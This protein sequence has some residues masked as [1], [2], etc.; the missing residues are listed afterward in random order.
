VKSLPLVI[1]LLCASAAFAEP[2]EGSVAQP[3]NSVAELVNKQLLAPIQKAE[4]RRSRF[5]RAAP[6]TRERRLRVLDAVAQTDRRGKEFYRFVI[7]E[8]RPFDEPDEWH[9]DSLIGCA[10]PSAR[11]VFVQRGEVFMPARSMLGEA[12]KAH[13]DACRAAPKD[14]SQIAS[15]ALAA[16]TPARIP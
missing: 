8:R 13:P 12:A 14:G 9:K 3:Q 7:D 2:P 16:P 11:E 5:S 6:V 10:Y 15:A 4:S 1:S